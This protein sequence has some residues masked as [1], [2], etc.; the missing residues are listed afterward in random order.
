MF[1]PHVVVSDI[2]MPGEDG[3]MLLRKLRELAGD[4]AAVPAVAVT[5]YARPEDQQRTLAAG[6]HAYVSKPIEPRQLIAAVAG[7]ARGLTNE[8]AG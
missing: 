7:M 4:D 1:A 5:A 3:I 8:P 6:Y 2:A